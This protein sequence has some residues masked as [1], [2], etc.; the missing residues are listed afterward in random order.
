[1][2]NSAKMLEMLD[3][4][5]ELRDRDSE[6]PINSKALETIHQ[7]RNLLKATCYWLGFLSGVL[8]SESVEKAE[9][10]P[11]I[12]HSQEFLSNFHDE[13]AAE[14]LLELEQAWPDISREAEGIIENIVD[15]RIEELDLNQGYNSTNLFY[16]FLK[17]IACDN[18]ISK[19]ELDIL[20]GYL[21][22]NASLLDD[23]RISDI[24]EH[25]IRVLEDGIMDSEKSEEIC[26]WI[27]RLV[28]D[29]FFDTGS[30][31]AADSGLAADLITNLSVNDL[32]GCSVVITGTFKK[33]SRRRIKEKL[34]LYCCA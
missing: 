33:Y 34:N 14:L 10:E 19:E 6:Y 26:D 3:K 13:D 4:L 31:S 29:S 2:S 18:V 12:L 21:S 24:R 15:M 5:R 9:L 7:E 11:L 17:G 27:S 8:S 1:M 23:P 20:I 32:K 30:S 16:G 22:R 25:T 28:G